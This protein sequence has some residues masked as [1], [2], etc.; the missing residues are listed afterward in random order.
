[1]AARRGDLPIG[2][3]PRNGRARG[4]PARSG[5]RGPHRGR[6]ARDD[7]GAAGFGRRH[8][9]GVFSR[10]EGHPHVQ[11]ELPG[12]VHLRR[13]VRDPRRRG[14]PRPLRHH[15]GPR[16]RP[17]V[18]GQPAH[19]HLRE[20][21]ASRQVSAW[22]RVPAKAGRGTPT[23][24]PR[25]ALAIRH[26]RRH[27]GPPRGCR[28]SRLRGDKRGAVPCGA[29]Q[30]R[31][32]RVELEGREWHRRPSRR[33]KRHGVRGRHGDKPRRPGPGPGLA[34]MDRSPS[35]PTDRRHE[36]ARQP[37]LQPSRR[38][39]APGGRRDLLRLKRR[40]PL[41]DRRGHRRQALAA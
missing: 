37:D 26:G 27:L 11:A 13:G 10:H 19:R 16:P 20:G 1:M 32:S 3:V 22:R 33:G 24:G 2:A 4:N 6:L 39:A 35:R 40:R 21:Q 34:A 29:R 38:H 17:A 23:R 36:A 30:R 8:R 7:R 28:R 41:C 25:P 9:P 14:W 31:R 15:P 5:K 12:D 18:R